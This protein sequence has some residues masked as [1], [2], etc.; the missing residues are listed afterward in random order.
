MK[1]Q[2]LMAAMLL[3]TCCAGPALA[4]KKPLVLDVWPG[5]PPGE[6]APVGEERDLTKPEENL[7]GG[8]RLIR[9]GNV[10][11]PTITVFRPSRAKDTGAAVVIAPGGGYRA[12]SRLSSPRARIH[13]S[14]RRGHV[15]EGSA[16]GRS[17]NP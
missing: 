6:T 15:V 14:Q 17:P 12:A 2:L 10:S 9:L 3:A 11:R 5:Q 4:A 7:V 16:V 8:R 1:L 13:S